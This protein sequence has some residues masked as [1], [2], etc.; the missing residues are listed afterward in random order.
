[1]S[2]IVNLDGGNVNLV[3]EL[4]SKRLSP[5]AAGRFL[6]LA[7]AF[8][9]STAPGSPVLVMGAEKYTRKLPLLYFLLRVAE[10]KSNALSSQVRRLVN[11]FMANYL[12]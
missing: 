3:L 2:P 4:C 1:M 10:K 8:L 12:A 7:S 5:S 6:P 11:D 9:N